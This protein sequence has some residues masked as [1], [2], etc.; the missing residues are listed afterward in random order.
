[1]FQNIGLSTL[2]GKKIFIDSIKK[3]S[4]KF[5]TILRLNIKPSTFSG[6]GN[7]AKF[8]F[9]ILDRINHIILSSLDFFDKLDY[10]KT[11]V[12][13]NFFFKIIDCS[14]NK[15]VNNIV[16]KNNKSKDYFLY[17]LFFNLK[18]L[19]TEYDDDIL[20]SLFQFFQFPILKKESE[21]FVYM[22]KKNLDNYYAMKKKGLLISL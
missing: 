21:E 10:I 15:E 19:K 1:M 11:N 5:D 6:F 3:K 14:A 12:N 17:S 2:S 9:S 4:S 22:W 13:N 8:F 16:L 20:I 18:D 7:N